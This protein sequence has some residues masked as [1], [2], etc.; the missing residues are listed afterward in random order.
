MTSFLDD[1]WDTTKNTWN[2]AL[3]TMSDIYTAK[4]TAHLRD[5]ENQANNSR[6]DS[7][8]DTTG[9]TPNNNQTIIVAGASVAVLALILLIRK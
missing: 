7:L 2:T 6:Q 5:L 1:L 9:T 8:A 3:D 4:Q